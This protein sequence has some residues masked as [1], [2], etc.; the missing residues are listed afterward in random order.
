MRT[1]TAKRRRRLGMIRQRKTHANVLVGVL[2]A[3]LFTSAAFAE[4]IDPDEPRIS[5]LRSK[6]GDAQSV[7]G[8]VPPRVLKLPVIMASHGGPI[9]V[10]YYDADAGVYYPW[11]GVS[12]RYK[13]LPW[14]NA[15][16]GPRTLNLAEQHLK[17]TAV[18][19]PIRLLKKGKKF[20]PGFVDSGNRQFFT[21]K[22]ILLDQEQLKS[23]ALPSK[24]ALVT[25][26]RL[27]KLTEVEIYP[28]IHLLMR[29]RPSARK[30]AEIGAKLTMMALAAR[31][32]NLQQIPTKDD[33]QLM[34]LVAGT[35]KL[36]AAVLLIKCLAFNIAPRS[37]KQKGASATDRLP[38]VRLLRKY[39]GAQVCPLL[40]AEALRTSNTW[41]KNRCAAAIQEIASKDQV[42]EL[43]RTFSLE[44]SADAAE[45]DFGK[46]LDSKNLDL[47]VPTPTKL[48][49]YKILEYEVSPESWLKTKNTELHYIL[50]DPPDE[51]KP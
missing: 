51:K 32:P 36:D 25:P 34:Q 16:S 27:G 40:I 30:Q 33:L 38:A 41:L 42:D 21:W 18:N 9:L 12:V 49:E 8:N 48:S 35:R 43:Q 17:V 37:S 23:A 11:Q 47:E 7:Q 20:A 2:G 1:L 39:F 6:G 15:G 4:N 22:G 50:K 26:D 29:L 24:S 28:T 14:L 44:P 31:I 5:P 45:G 19:P 13:N 46:L 3:L 10:G